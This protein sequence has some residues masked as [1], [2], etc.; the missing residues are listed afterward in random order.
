MCWVNINIHDPV[1]NLNQ[2]TLSDKFVITMI[3]VYYHRYSIN[4]TS[5]TVIQ[6]RHFVGRNIREEYSTR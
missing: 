3:T 5:L 1:G 2:Y 4:T 6:R